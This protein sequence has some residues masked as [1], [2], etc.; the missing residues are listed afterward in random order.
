MSQAEA[1]AAGDFDRAL[2]LGVP[3]LNVRY[4]QKKVVC[5][6]IHGCTFTC[7]RVGGFFILPI[8]L[9]QVRY[10]CCDVLV[11]RDAIYM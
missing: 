8:S 11:L 9:L 2:E 7:Y 3:Q 6:V 5:R 1:E 10:E 4:D